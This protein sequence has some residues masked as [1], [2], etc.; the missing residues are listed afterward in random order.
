MML[1]DT[2]TDTDE[3]LAEA[4]KHLERG[5]VIVYPTETLYGLGADPFRPSTP[6]TVQSIK[7]RP[8]DLPVALAVGSIEQLH[9]FASLNAFARHLVDAVLP[10]PV[11]VI[12]QPTQEVPAAFH[13]PTGKVG[14]RIPAVSFTR[15]LLSQFGPLTATSANIHGAAAPTTVDRAQKQLGDA[16]ACYLDGG[17]TQHGAPSTVLE[18]E[19]DDVTLLREGVW[20]RFDIGEVVEGC[21]GRL[22]IE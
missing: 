20:S 18:V 11:T 14:F 8:H 6:R 12:V 1:L 16:V 13:G 10:G 19:E 4:M 3:A 21:H 9:R 5:E 22:V 17:P 7:H 15:R 2:R